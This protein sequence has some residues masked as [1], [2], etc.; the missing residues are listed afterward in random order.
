MCICVKFRNAACKGL[1]MGYAGH[2]CH[3]YRW[4]KNGNM[5][6]Q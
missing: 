4:V 3:N 2:Q 1:N 6:Y 5:M